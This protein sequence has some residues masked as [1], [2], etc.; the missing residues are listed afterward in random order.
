MKILVVSEFIAPVRSVASVRWTK[1]AKYLSKNH[2]V[3][4]SV[5]TN[6]KRFSDRVKASFYQYDSSL[7]PD[8]QYFD[9]VYEIPNTLAVK[10]VNG[11]FVAIEKM[12]SLLGFGSGDS[13]SLDDADGTKKGGSI[14]S[15]LY[16]AAYCF[17]M[18]VKGRSYLRASRRLPINYGDYDA[19][20]STFSPR[21]THQLAA[22]VKRGNPSIAW[23]A[24]FRDPAF[25][26]AD[27]REKEKP[28]F[29]K[30]SAS[31]ADCIFTVW[32]N[33]PDLLGLDL[34]SN[35][36]NITNG[37]DSEDFEVQPT[38]GSSSKFVISYTGTLYNSN[39]AMS[40][41]SPL[42]D[43]LESLVEDGGMDPSLIEV[44]YAGKSGSEFDRQASGRSVI[45]IS[46]L[47]MLS[48]SESLKLQRESALLVLC[49][50]NTDLQQNVVTGKIFEYLRSG[51]PVVGL[52]SGNLAGS[53]AKEI[54]ERS[55]VGYCYEQASHEV[56]FLL[57]KSFL[58]AAYDEWVLFGKTS[59][60]LD[61]VYVR[62]FDYSEISNR[63]YGII[64]QL[65]HD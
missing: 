34:G 21:W 13:G 25:F 18:N 6:E 12:M 50:W 7:S 5:L 32:N 60:C 43:A 45:S 20:V 22:S 56:D 55:G 54:I 64:C 26:S 51:T 33:N 61:E 8:A 38:E 16:K 27:V 47:G 14:F 40:D 10:M 39:G 29:G 59:C 24:D 11:L 42:F 19:I 52:C 62:S 63:V 31:E 57:L 9:K 44:A 1:I 28:V 30:V 35:I 65:I 41:F 23:I 2:S 36:V 46:N 3:E 49:T 4:V 48:R 17:F 37:Y 15:S 53:S 58:K